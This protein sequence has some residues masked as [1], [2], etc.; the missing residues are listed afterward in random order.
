MGDASALPVPAAYGDNSA[1]S[2]RQARDMSRT[3]WIGA[4]KGGSEQERYDYV[5]ESAAELFRFYQTEVIRYARWYFVLTAV[6]LIGT[7][8]TPMLALFLKEGVGPLANFWIALPSGIAGLAAA[9]NSAFHL[10]DEWAQ[11]YFTLSALDVERDRF[12]VGASPEYSHASLSDAIDH[13][14]K[15]LGEL[16]M[17]EVTL[18]RQSMA[19]SASHEAKQG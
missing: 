12:L 17:S 1:N 6:T 5:L 8:G 18:W 15:R 16:V 3:K 14:Q 7:A 10:K 2:E 11:N 13:F 19:R 4:R 9:F